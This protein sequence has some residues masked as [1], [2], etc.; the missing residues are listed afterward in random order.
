ML[1]KLP[2]LLQQEIFP[3]VIET[4]NLGIV[5]KYQKVQCDLEF[6]NGIWHQSTKLFAWLNLV[7]HLHNKNAENLLLS[8]GLHLS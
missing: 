8:V 7:E 2:Q 3:R 4:E 1:N 5:Y 6:S